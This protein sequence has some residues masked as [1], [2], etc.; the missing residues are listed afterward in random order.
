[1]EIFVESAYCVPVR[2]LAS[3]KR[4][5][6]VPIDITAKY[7]ISNLA[8]CHAVPPLFQVSGA[9]ILGKLIITFFKQYIYNE[10]AGVT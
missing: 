4:C 7:S 2:A 6:S 9:N 5:G 3:A 10:V 1:M 8:V